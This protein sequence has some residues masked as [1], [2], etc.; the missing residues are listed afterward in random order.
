LI[1]SADRKWIVEKLRA[2]AHAADCSGRMVLLFVDDIEMDRLHQAHLN[3]KGTTDVLTFDMRDEPA[4][5]DIDLKTTIDVEAVLCVDEAAR[6]AK[7]HGHSQRAEL[8]LY[9]LHALLHVTGFDDK[10]PAKSKK[11]HAEEDR[12]LS[13]IGLGPLFA[14]VEKMPV[15]KPAAKPAG[16][17]PA[18][19]S[20]TPNPA[21][22]PAR[23]SRTS[24]KPK[25]KPA[26]KP[27]AK[28]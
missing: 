21:A 28:P 19:T 1:T 25:A 11:M 10:T 17:K 16:R 6:Q 2:L 13:A 3:I 23:A 7:Q 20:N 14:P 27:R 12:L 15:G 22:K 26:I 9:A 24:N 5:A 8:L 18:K 4:D